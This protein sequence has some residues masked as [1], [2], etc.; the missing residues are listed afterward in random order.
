MFLL[1]CLS[2]LFL[3]PLHRGE[4]FPTN[5]VPRHTKLSLKK[6]Q[7]LTSVILLSK[8]FNP[9]FLVLTYLYG[10]LEPGWIFCYFSGF[11]IL[12]IIL[13]PLH[14]KLSSS[15]LP[16]FIL[17]LFCSHLSWKY[18]PWTNPV[19]SCETIHRQVPG[20]TY[21]MCTYTHACVCAHICVCFRKSHR[22]ESA[23]EN[24]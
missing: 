2:I 14:I 1:V 15:L 20:I 13:F 21:V 9:V 22:Q 3:L 5:P 10:I 4:T 24:I 18:W 23:F 6:L 19:V 8:D 17:L 12:I 11:I 16:F 7:F